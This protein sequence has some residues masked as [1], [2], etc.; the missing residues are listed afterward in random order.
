[1]GR[2]S[3]PEEASYGDALTPDISIV[4]SSAFQTSNQRV[5]RGYISAGGL[6][7]P[8]GGSCQ[9]TSQ[10]VVTDLDGNYSIQANGPETVL[11]FKSHWI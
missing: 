5:R 10:G 1:V 11:V 3:A 8:R 7:I 6:T 4:F 9:G 2:R